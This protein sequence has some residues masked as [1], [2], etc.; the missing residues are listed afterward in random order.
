MR[1]ATALQQSLEIRKQQL[2]ATMEH[3]ETSSQ[4][5]HNVRCIA[6]Y[7]QDLSNAA[8]TAFQQ[9]TTLEISSTAYW[10]AASAAE[11]ADA[12]LNNAENTVQKSKAT[13]ASLR[14]RAAHLKEV[15]HSAMEDVQVHRQEGREE[16]AL[17]ADHAIK[18]KQAECNEVVAEC[19]AAEE[20]VHVAAEQVVDAQERVHQ[21][22]IQV[23][24]LE[25]ALSFRAKAA[26]LAK[27]AKE[28]MG[29]LYEREKETLALKN[30]LREVE[31]ESNDA[32]NEA[33]QVCGAALNCFISV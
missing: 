20:A 28:T 5:L 18:R 2:V 23:S 6:S 16:E 33:S 31:Q 25:A 21:K 24:Q 14:W 30:Q 19:A 3:L 8:E 15:V 11:A 9:Q 22:E 29:S 32:S 27:Q 26:S 10:E 4:A 7:A 1:A 12:E 13:V 17:A